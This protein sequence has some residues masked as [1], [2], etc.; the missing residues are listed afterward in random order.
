MVVIKSPTYGVLG[1]RSLEYRGLRRKKGL[2]LCKI[3]SIIHIH[4]SGKSTILILIKCGEDDFYL[5]AGFTEKRIFLLK[6]M[7]SGE[8]GH[9][10]KGIYYISA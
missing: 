4:L 9:R 7:G 3:N 1:Q 5:I 8:Y 2:I 6:E 10:D